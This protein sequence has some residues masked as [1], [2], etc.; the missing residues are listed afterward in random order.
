VKS[1]LV[2]GAGTMGRGIS[3]LF[4]LKG[5]AVALYDS[6]AGAAEGAKAKIR[7]EFYR[8]AEKAQMLK[9]DADQMLGNL[10]IVTDLKGLQPY[11]AIE[12][13]IEDFAAKVSVLKQM[14]LALPGTTIFASNTSS[15]SVSSLA[16]T[17][18]DPGR[19]LGLHFFN[20]AP[21]MSL[22]EIIPGTRTEPDIIEAVKSEVSALGKTGIVVRDSPGFVVNRVA[23]PFYLES[24]R[25]AEEGVSAFE[26][27]DKLC[28]SAGFKMGP[29]ELM[30]LIGIDINYSV[31]HSIFNSFHQEPRFR[32]SVLQ[33]QKVEAGELGRKSGKGFYRHS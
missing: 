9:I 28:R 20:P 1:I 33:K 19:F 26:P 22:I 16:G 6:A 12:A 25:L 15:L 24:L 5:Y 17:L 32:P 2:I 4:I 10:A 7:D 30:D 14:Q 11:L 23:R 27:T 8:S 31:S 13:V 29:F 21:I 3:K 18:E